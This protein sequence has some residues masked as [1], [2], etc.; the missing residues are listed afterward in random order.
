M[1]KAPCMGRCLSLHGSVDLDDADLLI[2]VDLVIAISQEDY[3]P[4]PEAYL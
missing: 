2:G 3:K 4:F 1:S